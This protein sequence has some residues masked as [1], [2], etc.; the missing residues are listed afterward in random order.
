MKTKT[1]HCKLTDTGNRLVIARRGVEVG[2][3]DEGG[4]KV[5]NTNKNFKALLC[6]PTPSSN[7]NQ[8]G[9]EPF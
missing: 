5:K 6:Q 8:L 2:E 7:S 3:M 4:Q 1:K 9:R